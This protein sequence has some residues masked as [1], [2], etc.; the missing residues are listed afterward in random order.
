M[1]NVDGPPESPSI[2]HAEPRPPSRISSTQLAT[3]VDHFLAHVHYSFPGATGDTL[4]LRAKAFSFVILS[5]HALL[6]L[7]RPSRHLARVMQYYFQLFLLT[8]SREHTATTS[9]GFC[10]SAPPVVLELHLVATIAGVRISA[11][12]PKEYTVLNLQ[13]CRKQVSTGSCP[14]RSRRPKSRN[15]HQC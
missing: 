1:S 14:R 3:S 9:R 4:P 2:V 11:K 12:S 10:S 7:L 13:S 15:H 6:I 5:C 8:H